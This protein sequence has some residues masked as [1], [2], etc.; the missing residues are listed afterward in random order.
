[1][2]IM[3]YMT[4]M[5]YMTLMSYMTMMSFATVMSFVT[6]ASDLV[7]VIN[8]K[9]V[10]LRFPYLKIPFLYC[11]RLF[12]SIYTLFG[13]YTFLAFLSKIHYFFGV[14]M[15]RYGPSHGTRSPIL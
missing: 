6:L 10:V 9:L 5:S 3:Y 15:Y 8:L 4:V 1:M 12:W 13:A 7:A 14:L 2:T 11:I